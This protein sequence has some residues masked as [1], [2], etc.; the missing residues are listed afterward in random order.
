MKPMR[1]IFT[2]LTMLAAPALAHADGPAAPPP[3][4]S[5][6]WQLR[7]AAAGNVVRS[8]TAVAAYDAGDAGGGTTVVSS[9]LASY[10]VTPSLAPV[11]RV[12]FAH[13]NPPVGDGANSMANP[14]VG[15][16]W[17]RPLAPTVK[18]AVFGGVALPLGTGGGDTPDPAVAAA[19]KAAMAAR[20]AMDNALFAVNYATPLVGADVAYV[21]GGLTV[22][23]EVTLLE[24][25]R[26][27]GEMKSPDDTITNMTSGLHVGYFPLP[28]LSVGAE[29]RYQRYLTTPAVVKANPAAR[30]NVSA[31]LGVRGHIS[32]G[33][34]RW[35]RP[36]LAYARGLDD[37]MSGASYHV[38]QIDLPFA[39]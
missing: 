10:K 39:F 7:P 33:G 27:R 37:P 20:S 16:T 19:N 28:F 3:P 13:D 11:L 21:A 32:L 14:V 17:G 24:P 23:G 15:V 18:L 6:A 22:Q 2:A 8:D 38:V 31:A 29:L 26:V 36:G 4:T 25:I 9:L 35:L 5:L 34:K 12:A 1:M 30:D